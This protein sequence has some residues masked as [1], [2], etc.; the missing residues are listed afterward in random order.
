[1]DPTDAESYCG[2]RRKERKRGKEIKS[3]REMRRGVSIHEDGGEG[4]CAHLEAVEAA[5]DS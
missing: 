1:M 4:L 2:V 3:K 5:S